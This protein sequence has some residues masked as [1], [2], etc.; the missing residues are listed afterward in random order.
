[1]AGMLVAFVLLA[2]WARRQEVLPG[3]VRFTRWVQGR[4]W[5]L[6]ETLTDATNWSMSGMPLTVGG[7]AFVGILLFR[8]RIDAAVLTAALVVRLLNGLLKRLIDSPRPTAELVEVIE[9]ADGFGYPSGH[10]SGAL[11]VVGALAWTMSRHLHRAEWRW[12][13]WTIAAAWI[14]LTGIGRIRVGAH[15]PSDVLGA[16]LWSLPVLVLIARVAI[17]GEQVSRQADEQSEPRV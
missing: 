9:E 1:L 13:T 15:W 14:V 6:L 11:L 16:W 8:N 3:D 7:L 17:R 4:D 2:F 12:L 5:P 10:A